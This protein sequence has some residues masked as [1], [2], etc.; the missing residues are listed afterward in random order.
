MPPLSR[1]PTIFLFVAVYLPI[2]VTLMLTAFWVLLRGRNSALRH[3]YFAI[4]LSLIAWMLGILLRVQAPGTMLIWLMICLEYLG[5]CALSLCLILF[6]TAYLEEQNLTLSLVVPLA[7]PI[8]LAYLLVVSNPLHQW[9]YV[10]TGNLVQTTGPLY[11]PVVVT[12]AIYIF[13]GL[14]LS[15]IGLVRRMQ[16]H[17][18]VAVMLIGAI[19]ISVI[20]Y[21]MVL[22]HVIPAVIDLKPL[23]LSLSVLVF[24]FAVLRYH[25]LDVTPL[26][27]RIILNEINSALAITGL[28]DRL[29]DHNQALARLFEPAVSIQPFMPVHV[30]FPQLKQTSRE[31]LPEKREVMIDTISGHQLFEWTIHSVLDR[32]G[33]AVG[34]VHRLVDIEQ[35]HQLRQ[36]LGEQ[37]KQLEEANSSLKH[38]VSLASDLRSMVV[39][40]RLAREMHDSIGHTLIILIAILERVVDKKIQMEQDRQQEMLKEAVTMMEQVLQGLTVIPMNKREEAA[41]GQLAEAIRTLSRDTALSGTHLETDL[42]GAIDQ[43]P[44]DH[45]VELIQICREAITNAVK[46]GHAKTIHLFLQSSQNRYDLVILD[47]GK[48]TQKIEKGFG[49]QNMEQRVHALGGMMRLQSDTSGFGIYITVSFP[50]VRD[51]VK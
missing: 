42:R 23:F 17:R 11:I 51:Q 46:H 36:L 21:T 24:G 2:M 10:Q 3:I 7:I 38:Y 25:L 31:Q 1:D 5:F 45:A 39:R 15:C 13:I 14:L 9:F 30:L 18:T 48:G 35:E 37:N 49:L 28:D 43:I 20:F 27:R 6:G 26:A 8:A 47:D 34:R 40:N 4:N 16:K 32:K 33:R 44:K 41:S 29:I 22:F 50:A 12:H 19:L